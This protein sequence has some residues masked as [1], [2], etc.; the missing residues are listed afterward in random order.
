MRLICPSC[1]SEYDVAASAIGAKGRMVRCASCGGE[2]FQAPEDDGNAPTV[3]EEAPPA[4]EPV[5]EESAP[6]A[7][8]TGGEV[9]AM[10]GYRIIDEA[11]SPSVT[12]DPAP[13]IERSFPADQDDYVP[14]RQSEARDTSALTASLHDDEGDVEPASGGGLASFVGGFATSAVLVGLFAA[15][16]IAAPSIVDAIPALGPA[17][18]GY[19]GVVDKGRTVLNVLVSG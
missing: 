8:A 19:V 16:Y 13:E 12:Y 17:M 7:A 3:V 1:Q 5:V 4:P 9:G 6:A 11:P 14:N 10:P 15:V 18:D 2:W